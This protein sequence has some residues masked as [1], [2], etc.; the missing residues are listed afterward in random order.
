M[1]DQSTDELLDEPIDQSPSGSTPAAPVA[2]PL[3]QVV[4]D[5]DSDI[6]AENQTSTEQFVNDA[7]IDATHLDGQQA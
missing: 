6:A 2:D 7:V 1:S 5:A 3:A 4:V